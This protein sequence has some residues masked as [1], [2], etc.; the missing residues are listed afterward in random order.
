MHIHLYPVEWGDGGEVT[1]KA[2]YDRVPKA[3]QL[4]LF[5]PEQNQDEFYRPRYEPFLELIVEHKL[6]PTIICEAKDS[7]D[8]GALEMK[9]FYASL[10]GVTV[11]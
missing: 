6:Y 8:V 7:Q 1:H 3:R 9:K 5:S 10:I 11:D 4:G 2:F